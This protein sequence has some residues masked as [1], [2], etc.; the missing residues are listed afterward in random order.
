MN[1][2][3]IIFWILLIIS[4]I[5]VF[6]HIFGNSPSEFIAI[7]LI[8]AIV[9]FKVWAVSER[10][11]KLEAKFSI[12]NNNIKNSFNNIKND[13]NSLKSDMSLIKKKLKV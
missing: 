7:M 1:I 8:I 9:V 12:L 10:Q 3:E 13:L 11:I 6:W 5:L 4:L 2:K